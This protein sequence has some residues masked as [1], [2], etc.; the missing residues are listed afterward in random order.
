MKKFILEYDKSSFH[1]F[2]ILKLTETITEK[3][4]DREQTYTN[5][6]KNCEMN[7]EI[8]AN[9][10]HINRQLLVEWGN[11]LQTAKANRNDSN[12]EPLIVAHPCLYGW[13]QILTLNIL[14]Y[15]KHKVESIKLDLRFDKKI[16]LN[17][18]NTQFRKN[19]DLNERKIGC[20]FLIDIEDNTDKIQKRDLYLIQ[21]KKIELEGDFNR[22]PLAKSLEEG[23]RSDD[24]EIHRLR[25]NNTRNNSIFDKYK[26]QAITMLKASSKIY[27]ER[28]FITFQAIG[29]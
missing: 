26:S 17:F 13:E 5:L 24:E 27:K 22:L 2:D 19:P 29:V 12:Y 28:L 25:R 21:V 20:D 4:N 7:N 6:K 11:I 15:F 16:I 9:K 8:I 18:Q 1:E 14:S 3:K 23:S 10:L